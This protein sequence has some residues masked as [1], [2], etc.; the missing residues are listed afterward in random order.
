MA[1]KQTC[2]FDV[3]DLSPLPPEPTPFGQLAIT[4]MGDARLEARAKIL[5]LT[6]AY[7][8]GLLVSREV[9]WKAIELH[10]GALRSELYWAEGEDIKR[11][12]CS[13]LHQAI[14]CGYLVWEKGS[15]RRRRARV[16]VSL[17]PPFLPEQP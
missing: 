13:P 12:R 1:Q 11:Q 4:V 17:P 6:L 8:S 9:G 3:A 15:S 2:I 5:I 14:N 7:L 10:S 16:T